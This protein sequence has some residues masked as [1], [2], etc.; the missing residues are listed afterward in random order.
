MADKRVNI[1]GVGVVNFPDSMSDDDIR[2]VIENGTQSRQPQMLSPRAQP[3]EVEQP[4]GFPRPFDTLKRGIGQITSNPIAGVANIGN[5]A[6]EAGAFPFIAADAGLR[7]V[8]AGGVADAFAYPFQKIAEGVQ[9]AENL[10]GRG[11]T[12]AGVSKNV[13][14]FGMGD[15]TAGEAGQA[16]SQL[17]QGLAQM[18]AGAGVAKG[19]RSLVPKVPVGVKPPVETAK[20]APVGLPDPTVKSAK[21]TPEQTQKFQSAQTGLKKN[22]TDLRR[23]VEDSWVDVKNMMRQENVKFDDKSNPYQ[24]QALYFGRL[25]ER[26]ERV[27]GTVKNI[28]ADI[29]ATSKKLSLPDA[30]LS[31]AVNKYLHAKHAPERNVALGEGAAGMTTAESVKLMKD[32]EALPYAAEVKR[33]AGQLKEVNRQV[34]DIALEGQLITKEVHTLLRE[35]YKDHVPLQR[36]IEATDN[37]GDFLTERGFNVKQ[38]GIRRAKGSDLPVA[39]IFENIATN[40]SEV[41]LRAEKNRVDL[42]TLNFARSNPQLGVFQEIRPKA[43]GKDFKDNILLEKIRDPDVLHLFENGKRIYLKIN[44]PTLSKALQNINVEHTP[45]FFKGVEAFTRIYSGLATRF[46]PEFPLSNKL[47]DIQEL[48]VTV[49]SMDKMGGKSA[50]KSVA[51]D[52]A[53]VKD[54]FDSIAG[55]DTP[56]AKLYDQMRADGGT[57]GGMALSTRKQVQIDIQKIRELNR[58]TP[59]RAAQKLIESVDNLNQIFEDSSRL[60]VY[61]TALEKGISRERAAWL[62]KESTINFNKKGTATPLINALYMFSNASVQGSAKML[63][64]MK[65]PKVAAATGLSV[66]SAVFAVNRWND[67]ANPNWREQVTDFDR[68]NYLPIVIPTSDGF[69]Y[70]LIPVSWGLKPMKSFFDATYDGAAGKSKGIG[71]AFGKMVSA[72]M[73]AYNPL[74]GGDIVSTLTPTILDVPVELARNQTF[75]GSMI[76]PPDYGTKPESQ[77][78]FKSLERSAS[79][80]AAISATREASEIGFEIS[81]ADL[82]Y[83]LQQYSGGSGRFIGKTINTVS[84][85]GRGELPPVREIPLASRFYRSRTEEEARAAQE[86]ARSQKT[87]TRRKS[88]FALPNPLN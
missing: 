20:P 2:R 29:V 9:G 25:Q 73:D 62:A 33:I 5:A 39:D 7:A 19:V 85:V 88:P 15:E 77:R 75:S 80:R 10:I 46:N 24:A 30:D 83:A 45:A 31:G 79:G 57:T 54:V 16:M 26:F 87:G 65:N 11:L 56:G 36:I 55:R 6:L 61:K 69:D 28:D 32:I 50:F 18:L 52:P 74:G 48:A 38:S 70:A 34:L 66:G 42:A 76:K 44:D 53:S 58:S 64:A 35:K 14:N 51:R 49:A 82:L 84:A 40:L 17:N 13:Q 1:P 43:I 63:R 71:D 60:S 3:A 37:F 41:T 21:P 86:R 8:G 22:W 67:L 68:A 23:S 59:R 12:A 4:G 72:T 47:R 81:P 78:Y 27:Q